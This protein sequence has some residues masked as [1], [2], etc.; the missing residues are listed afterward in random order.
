MG[1]SWWLPMRN[2]NA[3]VGNLCT[4]HLSC[5][6]LWLRSPWSPK[7]TH[8]IPP[9]WMPS[10]TS[11]RDQPQVRRPSFHPI[12]QNSLLRDSPQ[13]ISVTKKAHLHIRIQPV[14]TPEIFCAYILRCG[15]IF[16]ADVQLSTCLEV[17]CFPPTPNLQSDGSALTQT[18]LNQAALPYWRW[19]GSAWSSY[20]T[21]RAPIDFI[22]QAAGKLCSLWH[23]KFPAL[24]GGFDELSR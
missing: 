16:S 20:A 14:I 24:L 18:G 13:V 8:S 12:H 17:Q 22:A 15:M 3:F 10:L 11:A 5:F 19:R 23:T 2:S 4:I 21:D 7:D 9:A 1:V 6:C